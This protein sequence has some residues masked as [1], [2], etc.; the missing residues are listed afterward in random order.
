MTNFD[1]F[2][3]EQMEDPEF[4]A[5]YDSFAVEYAIKQAMID[6]RKLFAK[7]SPKQRKS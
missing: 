1:D 5:A 6:I 4:K 2:L 3:K 7:F